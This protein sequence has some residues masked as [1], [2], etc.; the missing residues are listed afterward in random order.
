MLIQTVDD[1]DLS[2]IKNEASAIADNSD[3][4]FRLIAVKA[5]SWN[6]S[7]TTKFSEWYVKRTWEPE[8]RGDEYWGT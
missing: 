8:V 3:R 5:D 6:D 2:L 7:K 1:H 4:D